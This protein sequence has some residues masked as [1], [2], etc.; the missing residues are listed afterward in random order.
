MTD[1]FRHAQYTTD[2]T[3]IDD[4]QKIEDLN[5]L[6][7]ASVSALANGKGILTADAL[8]WLRPEHRPILNPETYNPA[9]ITAAAGVVA[10]SASA[11]GTEFY[12]NDLVFTMAGATAA[13]NTD[14]PFVPDY[15]NAYPS[16]GFRIHL[17]VFCTDWTK[18]TELLMY[19]V[20]NKSTYTERYQFGIVVGGISQY[21]MTDPAFSSAWNNTYRTIIISADQRTRNVGTGLNA[22][23]GGGTDPEAFILQ[24]IRFRITTSAACTIKINR[25]YSPQWPI[26]MYGL[27]GDGAYDTFRDRVVYPMAALGVRGTVDM[28]QPG[29]LF[30]APYPY[31]KD[32]KMMTDAGWD[33][34]GHLRSLTAQL[35]FAGTETA[36]EIEFSTRSIYR[37][38]QDAGVSGSSLRIGQFLQN[39][40]K[41]NVGSSIYLAQEL[42]RCG[43]EIT[44]G[45]CVDS[46]FG[47]NPWNNT[48]TNRLSAY[49]VVATTISGTNNLANPVGYCQGWVPERGKYN[50]TVADWF[51]ADSVYNI[52]SPLQRDTY[53]GSV[54]QT[55]IDKCA[56]YAD[57]CFGYTHNIVQY[58]GTNPTIY[59]TGINYW[60]A[61]KAD[62]LEKQAEGKLLL[63]SM[64]QYAFLTYW[65]P[66]DIYLRWDGEWC[67]RSDGSIAF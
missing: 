62:L 30:G 53:T 60:N 38:L 44:R 22:W 63:L 23:A 66:D 31:A 34:T 36:T 8:A 28:N 48:Y 27:I 25:I 47:I 54:H 18:V 12:R 50:L 59:D 14:V 6:Q 43:I 10:S 2:G 17:R 1:N 45:D 46:Q 51:A 24:S 67:N 13:G 57:A 16:C 35:A 3:Q 61:M 56:K 52:A 15:Y 58:D 39:S 49:K 19:F 9:T 41:S 5:S 37:R 42:K 40:G 21:G 4:P 65:R 26:G 55:I 32:L 20:Q 64:S 33:V 29:E 11:A 7:S